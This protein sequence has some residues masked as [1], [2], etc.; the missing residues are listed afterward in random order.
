MNNIIELCSVSKAFD[1]ETVLDDIT[2]VIRDK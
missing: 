2:L 1:G